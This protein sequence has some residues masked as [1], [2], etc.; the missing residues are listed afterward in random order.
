VFW[1]CK[2]GDCGANVAYGAYGL[3]STGYLL[4]LQ[5]GGKAQSLGSST[6]F[7]VSAITCARAQDDRQRG[8]TAE[9][10]KKPSGR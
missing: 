10:V 9:Q 4:Q 3:Q 5:E 2:A 8:R 6:A 7:L 1:T